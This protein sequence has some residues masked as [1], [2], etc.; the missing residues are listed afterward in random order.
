MSV[1]ELAHIE[2]GRRLLLV[3]GDLLRE[4][5]DAI[6]NAANGGL[7]HGGGV[8]AAISQA[9]GVELD[10]E[11]R[12]YVHEH[13]PIPVGEAVVTTAGELDFKGV[14]HAVGPRLGDGN[15]QEKL[16][17][18][19]SN[20]L[21]RTHEHGWKSVA[22]PAISSGIYA[23]PLETCARAYVAG[24]HRHFQSRPDSSLEEVRICLF[25]GPL[26]DLVARE[27]AG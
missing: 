15:E 1:K 20:A 21:L 6:V 17:Q 2:G 13:G 7:A 19:V 3:V 22:M 16:T 23:V 27:M 12:A 8:A 10:D 14:I 9:A 25:L 24:I 5:V 18:A 26:V 11:G 4:P